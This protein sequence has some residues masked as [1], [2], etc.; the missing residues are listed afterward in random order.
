MQSL[1]FCAGLPRTGSTVLM[2]IIQQNPKIFTTSTDPFPGILTNQILTRSRYTESFQAMSCETADNAVYGMA[3]GATAGWYEGLTSKPIVI[4][5]SRDWSN[6]SHLFPKS[7]HLVLVRDIRDIAESFDRV[8]SKIK[9]LHTY[10]DNN[11]LYASM[12]E[13][14]KY[15]YHFNSA[16]AFSVA[17]RNEIPKYLDMFLKDSST[18]KFVR[19]EDVLKEPIHMLSRIY[20]FLNIDSYNHDLNNIKQAAMFEHDN[21]YFKEKTDH[22]TY[23]QMIKWSEPKRVLSEKFHNKVVDKNEWFYRAFYPE[24]LS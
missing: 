9:A 10:D 23:P 2:N 1:H 18:I 22:I 20:E 5:K 4:S 14:Q 16:N 17:L 6:L 21:A 15:Q 7:K 13:D 11:I 8:N 19:Y 3:L 24:V 12:T